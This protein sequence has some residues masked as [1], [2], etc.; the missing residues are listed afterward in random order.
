MGYLARRRNLKVTGL[1][2]GK[3]VEIENGLR[4]RQAEFLQ[5]AALWDALFSTIVLQVFAEQVEPGR[6]AE[7]HHHHV[8]S[9]GQIVFDGGGGSGDVVLRKVRAVI[10]HVDGKR[11]LRGLLVPR[12]EVASDDLV[13][14][15][16]FSLE[17]DFDCIS[18]A[19][20]FNA[21]SSQLSLDGVLLDS[22]FLALDSL[23]HELMQQIVVLRRQREFL[24]RACRSAEPAACRGRRAAPFSV[25]SSS[26]RRA[27][28]VACVVPH[29]PDASFFEAM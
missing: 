25:A 3:R 14:Q 10:S 18:V 6:N 26:A 29:A 13:G 20:F 1:R 21:A 15:S 7:I 11:F 4:R 5:A 27:M 22:V 2:R 8:R 17:A 24:R 28:M 19:R 12:N 9:L 23:E 16:A